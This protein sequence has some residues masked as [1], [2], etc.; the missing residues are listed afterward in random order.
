MCFI[1]VSVRHSVRRARRNHC[2]S[3]SRRPVT[4]FHLIHDELTQDDRLIAHIYSQRDRLKI[5]TSAELT[6]IDHMITEL[7]TSPKGRRFALPTSKTRVNGVITNGRAPSSTDR[8]YDEFI[9]TVYDARQ[10]KRL[11]SLLH[12]VCSVMLNRKRIVS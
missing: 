2:I 3:I 7:V 1:R 9:D 10:T 4:L 6:P 5:V 8:R 11:E 12:P